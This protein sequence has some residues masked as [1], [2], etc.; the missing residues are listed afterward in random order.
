VYGHGDID[1]LCSAASVPVINALSDTHHPLQGLADLLTLRERF[2]SLEGL[3]LAW[4]G[5]GNNIAHTLL[6]AAGPC[7]FHLRLATPPGYEPAPEV[8]ARARGLAEAAGTQI[9]LGADPVEAVAGAHAVVTDTWVS[10]GQEAAAAERKA[11]F[12]G[13]QVT[14]ALCAGAR[15]DWVFLHCLPRK[16]QEVDDHVFYGPRSLVWDEAE[17]R[18]W[19]VMAVVLAQLLGGADLPAA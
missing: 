10:M 3:T 12:A 2:G 18:R 11:A 14:E 5:D 13:Y 8:L 16:P 15:K 7:G 9:W 19:T 17:N 6:S 4:V 1:T